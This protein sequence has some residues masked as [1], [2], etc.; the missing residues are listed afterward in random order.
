MH[1]DQKIVKNIFKEQ[2]NELH[3]LPFCLKYSAP[4]LLTHTRQ[5]LN[6]KGSGS[7]TNMQ[8]F[9]SVHAELHCHF[10]ARAFNKSF[11]ASSTLCLVIQP[12]PFS[13][14]CFSSREALLL[15]AQITSSTHICFAAGSCP[16]LFSKKP[17][18]DALRIN[19][20]RPKQQG[21]V[22]G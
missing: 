10:S 22:L 7:R 13:V 15:V 1:Q 16:L 12:H 5:P 20:E 14:Y 3:V 18:G 19:A 11:Q 21:Y 6:F 8:Q 9:T 2:Q 4:F 17:A